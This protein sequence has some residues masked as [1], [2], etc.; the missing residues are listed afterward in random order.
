[1]RCKP[2]QNRPLVSEVID[3]AIPARVEQCDDLVCVWIDPRQIGTLVR[4]AAAAAQSKVLWLGFTG[5]LA[6]NDVIEDMLQAALGFWHQAVF[7]PAA[8]ALSNEL[9]RRSGIANHAAEE[10]RSRDF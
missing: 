3:P 8:G 10:G 7:T 2:D 4:V 1:M 6:R 5:V 9:L